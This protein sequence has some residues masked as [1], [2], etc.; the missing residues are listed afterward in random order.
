M[1]YIFLLILTNWRMYFC[2]QWYIYICVVNVSSTVTL[3]RP[4]VCRWLIPCDAVCGPRQYL[5][6]IWFLI[7]ICYQG[8]IIEIMPM[9]RS[10]SYFMQWRVDCGWKRNGWRGKLWI[11]NTSTLPVLY[12]ALKHASAVKCHW[13]DII[14]LISGLHS[15]PVCLNFQTF[16]HSVSTALSLFVFHM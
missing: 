6:Q 7:M 10:R 13:T 9:I 11:T 5:I 16:S 2:H 4:F 1:L 15:L 12:V 3:N 8:C 14:L